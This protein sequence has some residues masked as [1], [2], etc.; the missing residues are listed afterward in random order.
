[1]SLNQVI[2][3]VLLSRYFVR[4]F[5][6][7]SRPSVVVSKFTDPYVN[8]SIGTYLTKKVGTT[9]ASRMLFLCS[10]HQ[11]VFTGKNQNCW[12]EC[13]MM[14]M[15]EDGIP[16]LLTCEDNI[17]KQCTVFSD[18]LDLKFIDCIQEVFV[19]K[20]YTLGLAGEV[21]KELSLKLGVSH[22]ENITEFCNY[23]EKIL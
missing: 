19:G 13:D 11:G 2:N 12:K 3:P 15:K 16:I 14:K 7:I 18:S 4:S 8:L 17:I 21:Q 20:D 10:S 6:Y 22:S 23:I 9:F 5:P 1:M